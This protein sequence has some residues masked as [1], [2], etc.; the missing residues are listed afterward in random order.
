MVEVRKNKVNLLV[1]PP[2]HAERVVKLK[3]KTA[4]EKARRFDKTKMVPKGKIPAKGA[5]R[6]SFIDFKDI[7]RKR[8]PRFAPTPPITE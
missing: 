4:E 7:K 1:E 2:E 8:K 3:A 6:R 5:F